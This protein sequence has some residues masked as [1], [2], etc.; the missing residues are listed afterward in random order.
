MSQL[1]LRGAT[2][3]QI[4]DA[5]ADSYAHYLTMNRRASA[6]LSF[7]AIAKH[8]GVES[9][10]DEHHRELIEFADG[11]NC[12]YPSGREYLERSG[13]VSLATK[14]SLADVSVAV[15]IASATII[16]SSVEEYLLRLCRIGCTLN[17]AKVIEWIGKQTIQIA[18]L[19]RESAELIDDAIEAWIKKQERETVLSRWDR[20]LGLFG[21][22]DDLKSSPPPWHF[23]R[24]LLE[25]FDEARHDG[26][27]KNG[28]LLAQIDLPTFKSQLDRAVM[29]LLFHS[30][31]VAGVKLNPFRMFLG[32]DWRKAVPVP[33]QLQTIESTGPATMD[34]SG[35]EA[36]AGG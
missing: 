7:E 25:K 24:Q 1:P 15:K 10:L 16:H 31:K 28:E 30:T 20:Y 19:Q 3:D 33:S 27:H 11:L 2:T 6:V 13:A 26:V 14:Q 4:A 21:Y 23:D 34:H 18:E 5:L 17:R 32:P 36:S 8:A 22:P 9:R 35:S 12:F 29:V